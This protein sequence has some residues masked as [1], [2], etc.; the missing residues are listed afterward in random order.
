MLTKAP[1]A[2]EKDCHLLAEGCDDKTFVVVEN[3]LDNV[4]KALAVYVNG[5][6]KLAKA[7]ESSNGLSPDFKEKQLVSIK[8]L[9]DGTQKMRQDLEKCTS[10]VETRKIRKKLRSFA[11]NL[12]SLKRLT[13]WQLP[14]SVENLNTLRKLNKGITTVG[15]GSCLLLAVLVI[16]IY[17]A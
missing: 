4:L 9:L 14:S 5:L 3:A 16:G 2:F 1:E 11:G 15:L 17:L 7:F 8:A 10:Y 13:I 12:D 6:Q